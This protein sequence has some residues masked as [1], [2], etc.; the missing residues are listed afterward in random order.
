MKNTP[1]PPPPATSRIFRSQWLIL[2]YALLTLGIASAINLYLEHGRTA[3]REQERLMTQARVVEQNIGFN[4]IAVNKAL[5]GLSQQAGRQNNGKDLNQQLTI[6]SDAMPGVRTLLQIDAH[7]RVKAASRPELIGNDYS[8][9]EYFQIAKEQPER[10]KLY[11]GQPF[12]TTLGIFTINVV[13]VISGPHGEFAGIVAATL[14]PQYFTPLLNSVLYAPDMWAAIA[15]DSGR[16]FLIEPRQ[17][18]IEGKNIAQPG[19]FFSRHQASKEVATVHAGTAYITGQDRLLVWRTVNIDQIKMDRPLAVT[20]SRDL[21]TVFAAWRKDLLLQSGLFALIALVATL[22]LAIYQRSQRKLAAKV[23]EA[24]QKLKKTVERL[25]LATQAASVGTWDLN[26]SS[27]QLEW[28]EVMQTLYGRLPDSPAIDYPGWQKMLLPADLAAAEKALKDAISSKQLFQSQF[29]ILRGDGETRTIKALGRIFFDAT[30]QAVRLVGTNEDITARLH[31]EQALRDS[32]RFMRTLT[33]IL[34]GMVGYWNNELRCRFA[35]VSYLTWFGKSSEEMRNIH[36]KDLMGSDLFSKNEPYILGA[37]R[38][39]AQTFER[40]LIKAD[41]STGYTWAHYIPDFD[42]QEVRGFFVMVTDITDLKRTQLQLEQRTAEAEAASQAKSQF[43]ANMSHEIRTPMNAILGLLQLLQRTELTPRQYDYA[44]KVEA[45]AHSLLGIL[46]DILDFSKVEAGKLELEHIPFQVDDLLRNLAVI[47]SASV[48]DKDLEVLLNIDQQLPQILIGDA[49]RLQQIILNLAGN[50]IKFTPAGEVVI[51]M[52]LH[53]RSAEQAEIDFSVRDTGIGI[54]ADKLAGLFEGFAQADASTSRRFGGSGLGLTISQRLTR[55]MGG[56]LRA[57][58]EPGQGSEFYFRVSFPCPAASSQPAATSGRPLR[59]LI[60]D[61]SASARQILGGMANAQGWQAD[62]VASGND[63]IAQ[64]EAATESAFPYDLVMVDRRMPV[65]DGWETSQ[66]LRQLRYGDTARILLM[67][68]AHDREGLAEDT[69]NKAH[70]VDGLLI[71]PVIPSQLLESVN[72]AL[73]SP[74]ASSKHSTPLAPQRPLRLAGLRVLVVE[75]NQI[76][77]QVAQE[78]LALEGAEVQAASSGQ[79]GIDKILQAKPPFDAVLMDIQMPGMDGYTATRRLR[80]QP[81]LADLPII[82]ITANALPQDRQACLAAGMN[83]H[84]GKPINIDQLVSTLLDF[85]RPPPARSANSESIDRQEVMAR[86]GNSLPLL[87]RMARSFRDQ[88]GNAAD[89]LQHLLLRGEHQAAQN[90]LHSLKGAAATLGANTLARFA[91]DA[92]NRLRQ[93]NNPDDNQLLVQTLR[94]HLLDA[95]QS[96]DTLAKQLP[97][98]SAN[99]AMDTAA[100][101]LDPAALQKKLARLTKLLAAG[102]LKA[103]DEYAQLKQNSGPA[104]GKHLLALDDAMSKLDLGSALE[105]IRN[106]EKVIGHA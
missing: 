96:L 104:L 12:R 60:I 3:K 19:T 1:T 87:A 69:A 91:A 4:L 5:A 88:Q 34:P 45:A 23:F 97:P 10:D 16:V 49:L 84:I 95:C 42:G 57:S 41:G 44:H 63:A 105:K 74:R 29:R 58:S 93:C 94:Q 40:T 47:L 71:K 56:E 82:A 18:G 2:A 75:D 61:D 7:G 89:R 83:E 100:I 99:T 76:N 77:Q 8:Q 92:E 98:L 13:R 32:E 39:E 36:I 101:P 48:Q 86:F 43:L 15:H 90:E 79:E 81:E 50:A 22:S 37:L 78:L 30:G 103:L 38:G 65:M 52:Q 67:V 11:I 64:I 27:G 6:L 25:H 31:N 53:N 70:L 20:V 85:C 73:G 26:L 106:L 33:D 102:N 51:S 68:T 62:S 28:D 14:D 54:A 55:L 46:N 9:R 72:E 17:D 24:E 80:D 66:H 21:P 35:N 59:L